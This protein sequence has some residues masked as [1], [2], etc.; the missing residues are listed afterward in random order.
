MSTP[1]KIGL[2]GIGR[3]GYSMHV[4][5]LA[6]RRDKFVFTAGCDILPERAEAFARE[7]QAKAYT[8]IEDI[9]ADPHVEL[10]DIATV[11]RDH[12]AHA[13]LALQA[14][15]DVLLEKPFAVNMEQAGRLIELG[16]RPGG[17]RLYVRHNRRFERGFEM[18]NEII[19]SG[20][21][22]TV[23]EI[24]LTRNGYQRRNDWQTLKEYGGGQILNWG[25]HIIDHSLCFCGGGYEDM[26]SDLRHVTWAGDR[27]D[28]VKIVF[29][30]RNGRIVDMEISGGTGVPTPEYVVYGT[31]GGLISEPR[32][33]RLRYLD[34]TVALPEVRVVPSAWPVDAD[35]ANSEKLPW[36][37]EHR[38]IAF[39]GIDRIWD[40][41]YDSI[42]GGELPFPSRLIKHWRSKR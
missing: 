29:R 1:I 24:K 30:G 33:L 7:F 36:V 37:E 9:V 21:L 41:L 42:R 19:D 20:L 35:F 31:R 2:V 40:A 10:V 16:R 18:V 25:P 12:Y 38:E 32:G 14:G 34:P 4:R 15:K 11:S 13:R 17:P 3:A 26:F 22:G 39:E 5:E 28:H 8:R 6:D 27:E 23:F